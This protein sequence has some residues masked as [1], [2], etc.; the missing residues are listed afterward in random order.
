MWDE[1]ES[2]VKEEG[3]LL[4]ELTYLLD[5]EAFQALEHHGPWRYEGSRQLSS[6]LE[7]EGGSILGKGA[8][9]V[10]Y[11]CIFLVEVTDLAWRWKSGFKG[12]QFH[13]E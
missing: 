11:S 1:E 7:D 3:W 2:R 6:S 9:Y 4:E 10:G 12:L 5:L 13:R 8:S